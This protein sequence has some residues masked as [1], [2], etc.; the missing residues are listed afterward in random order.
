MGSPTLPQSVP[1][2]HAPRILMIIEVPKLLHVS[3]YIM[4][5]G[6]K[7]SRVVYCALSQ[8]YVKML[9]AIINFSLA[10]FSRYLNT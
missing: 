10:F 3:R 9:L 4:Y 7:K 2:Y 1:I 8:L 6:R 5:L